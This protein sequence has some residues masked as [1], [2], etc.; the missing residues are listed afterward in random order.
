MT[1]QEPTQGQDK[2]PGVSVIICCYN[3]ADRLPETLAHL[4]KQ[5]VPNGLHW[6]IL[7][8]D[9]AST[10]FT[11]EKALEIWNRL[12]PG[13][14]ILR[15]L[16]ESKPGQQFARTRGAKEA[17]YDLLIFCD[18][19][20][21]LDPGYVFFSSQAIRQDERYGAA[22]GQNEPATDA[23]HYPDW[24]ETYRDKYA[25]GI[26]ANQSGDVGHRGFVIGAGMLTRR[27]LFL[28]MYQDK[29]PSLLNGRKG[30]R[31]STGDDF[32]Y[33]KRLL[34]RGYRLYYEENMKLK[35]F[36][37]KER[38]TLTYRDR[39]MQG[40]KDAGLVLDEYDLAIRVHN[41]YKNKN[42][43]RLLLL[44]PFRILFVRL[45][46]MNRVL[47]DEQLTLYYLSPFNS[48]KNPVRKKIKDFIY[49]R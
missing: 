44:T 34:L 8:I 46:M 19:D 37:P 33:C 13:S 29:F 36:I 47:I 10:D 45:G 39:L 21:W 17:S 31:L 6:E 24:F 23:E 35:H 27:S 48:N 1:Q 38:L 25:L 9:N 41:R 2:D 4:A 32:E 12:L 20:N 26:P 28:E 3:S 49:G 40:I 14:A 43:F 7:V 22:G 15:V 30:K 16:R 5:S 18:D 11:A 42:R